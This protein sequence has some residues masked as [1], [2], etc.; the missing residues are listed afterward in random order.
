VIDV[1]ANIGWHAIHAAM[2]DEVETIVAFEPDAFNAWLLD[3]NLAVNAIDKV[4]VQTCAVGTQ[5]GV[6]RLYRYK[7]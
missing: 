6:I 4:I 7:G 1:G 5:R 2:H 3:R